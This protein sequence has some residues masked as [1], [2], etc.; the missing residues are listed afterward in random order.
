MA[1]R[2]DNFEELAGLF[3]TRSN[4]GRLVILLLLAKTEISVMA[5]QEKLQ[6]SIS[7]LRMML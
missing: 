6:F 1:R 7:C 2:T 4:E 5:I 3:L